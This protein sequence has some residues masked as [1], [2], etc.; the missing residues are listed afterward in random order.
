MDLDEKR[1]G[2]YYVSNSIGSPKR[3]AWKVLALAAYK[4]NLT[5]NDDYWLGKKERRKILDFKIYPTF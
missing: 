1:N 3:A 5:S 4:A 2:I